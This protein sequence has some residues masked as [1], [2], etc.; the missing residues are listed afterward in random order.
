MWN[1][2]FN[3]AVHPSSLPGFRTCI[4]M[5]FGCL[6]CGTRSNEV[7]ASGAYGDKAKK[8]T[9]TV[10]NEADL[11]RDVL[12]SDTASL[13]IPELEFETCMGALGGVFTT[14]EGLIVKVRIAV[15]CV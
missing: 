4:L 5:A 10:E 6:G 7:K 3:T 1:C 13:A 8:W 15:V 2:D 12:K 9:L 14:V 11:N